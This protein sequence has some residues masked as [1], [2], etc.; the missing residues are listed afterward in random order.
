MHSGYRS[1][2]CSLLLVVGSV[3]DCCHMNADTSPVV[4][5]HRP[6]PAHGYC[7]MSWRSSVSRLRRLAESPHRTFLV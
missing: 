2:V 1:L 3:Q 4:I 5:Y 7:T 6:A